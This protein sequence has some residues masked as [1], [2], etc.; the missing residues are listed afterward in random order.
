[1]ML[2]W[3]RSRFTRTST[4]ARSGRCSAR[5]RPPV[6]LRL[7]ALEDRTVL[8]PAFDLIGVSALRRDPAFAD[9]DGR[10]VSVAIIDSGLDINHPLLPPGFV[11][12]ADL[13][14]GGPTPTP[15]YD[16][17]THVA[18]IVGAR[19]PDI[20][21]APGVG[22]IGLQIGARSSGGRPAVP[23]TQAI[24]NALEWV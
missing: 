10:G 11:S 23:Q 13:V 12:G 24:L 20:G 9:I 18:G 16:H 17:G 22:L 7:E 15:T 8:S 1:M 14:Y 4:A 19:H 5:S 3:L 21:V 6:P 2:H